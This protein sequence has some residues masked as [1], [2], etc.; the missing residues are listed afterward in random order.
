MHNLYAN[1][2]DVQ[3]SK[4]TLFIFYKTE[5]QQNTFSTRHY[6]VSFCVSQEKKF[7]SAKCAN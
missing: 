2:A 1:F 3:L 4:F 5:K 6:K 7:N